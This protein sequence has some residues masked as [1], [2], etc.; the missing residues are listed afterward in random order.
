MRE[1]FGPFTSL[2][3]FCRRVDRELV[4][5][6][7]VQALIKLGAFNFTGLARAQLALAE[8]VYSSTGDLLRAADRN[9]TGL[10]PLEEELAQLVSRHLDVAEWPPE[11]LAV[12]QEYQ[13]AFGR[14]LDRDRQL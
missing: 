5:R 4:S 2:L 8:Q 9:P 13:F 7:A 10:G 1:A 11:I 14:Q 12:V 6:R 3:D